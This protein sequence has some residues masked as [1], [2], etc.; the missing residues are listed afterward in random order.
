MMSSLYQCEMLDESKSLK[1]YLSCSSA[2][3]SV[4]NV[5]NDMTSG[6][7]IYL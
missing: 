2:L 4:Q 6:K 5:C 7:L 3:V 1:K